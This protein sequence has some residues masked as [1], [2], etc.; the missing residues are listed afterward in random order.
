MT[1]TITTP[2]RRAVVSGR[3]R[4]DISVHTF[5]GQLTRDLLP[6]GDY[7]VE[8]GPTGLEDG[9]KVFRCRT[10]KRVPV[11]PAPPIVF[12][13]IEPSTSRIILGLPFR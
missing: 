8:P 5:W 10:H 7:V 12:P 13:T 6:D 11:R 1:S 4:G 3:H 2:I 9:I